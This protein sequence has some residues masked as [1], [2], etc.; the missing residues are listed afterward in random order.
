MPGELE[1]TI[2][3]LKKKVSE[4]KRALADHRGKIQRDIILPAMEADTF[5]LHD[6]PAYIVGPICSRNS[7][8]CIGYNIAVS[9]QLQGLLTQMNVARYHHL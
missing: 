2:T 8:I 3:R 1:E 6:L 5:L 4:A 9:D 7:A